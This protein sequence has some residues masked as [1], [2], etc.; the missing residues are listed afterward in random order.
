MFALYINDLPSLVS[1]QL[2]MFADDIKLYRCIRSAKDCLVLQ[3][4]INIMLDWSKQWLLSFNVS[5]CKVLHIGSTPYTGNYTLGGNQLENLDNFRD[6][7]IKIDSKL[8]FHIHTNTVV[9]KAYRVL[10]LICKSFECKDSDVMVKLYKTL[11]RPIIEY[12][13]V[14]WGPFYVL[15]NQKIEIIQRKATRI[16]PSISH[17]SYHDRLRHLN[18]QS[19]QHRRR[20]GD[21]IYLYQTL[22][23]AYDI[24]NQFFTPSTFTTTRGHTKKLFKHH[25]NSYTRSKFFSNRVTNDWNSLPQFIVDSSSVNEFKMLLDRHYSNCLFDYV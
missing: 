4:D 10:G 6:L 15:D 13:N 18:L 14:L 19:L 21:L 20:R 16:I 1:S 5:K 22:K 12:N 9:R 7:G 11:V 25:V 17:L 24:D 3:N 8:K 23:G 2:L